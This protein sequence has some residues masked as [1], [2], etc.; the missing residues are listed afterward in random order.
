VAPG[1]EQQHLHRFL[2]ADSVT[3]IAVGLAIGA[4]LLALAASAAVG[5]YLLRRSR[6]PWESGSAGVLQAAREESRRSRRMAEIASTIDLDDVLERTLGGAAGL[7]GVDAAMIVLPLDDEDPLVAAVGMSAEEASRQ[8][9]STT[10]GGGARAVRLG[11]RYRGELETAGEDELI[12]GGIAV[13][14]Q[15]E[16]NEPAGTLAA[17]WRGSEGAASDAELE[18]LAA[19]CGPALR[20]ARRFARHAVWPTWT[21]SRACT[22]AATSTGLWRASAREQG[23]TSGDSR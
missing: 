23:V 13:P 19:S 12:R 11:Y 7:A 16:G 5:V 9:V 18:E 3:W 21:P 6:R 1:P 14:L 20:N 4:A 10:S 8:P 15:G 17:F 2:L 22:T